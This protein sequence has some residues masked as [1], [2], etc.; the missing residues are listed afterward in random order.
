MFVNAPPK[1]PR[2]GGASGVT[3]PASDAAKKTFK[4]P[5][6][7]IRQAEALRRQDSDLIGTYSSSILPETPSVHPP[8]VAVASQPK[9]DRTFHNVF[10]VQQE[11][12]QSQGRPATSTDSL[13]LHL[14]ALK[15]AESRQ[16]PQ[17]PLPSGSEQAE[18][19]CRV[20]DQVA[21]SRSPKR[22]ISKGTSM[23]NYK[24]PKTVLSMFSNS[25]TQS[26]P[27]NKKGKKGL[28]VGVPNIT[29][30]FTRK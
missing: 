3:T 23:P 12:N 14:G 21:S 20:V 6:L 28:T 1:R 13:L 19:G 9:A 30:F 18:A 29:S 11:P 16:G 27:G 22:R 4:P 2:S 7:S 17:A 10:A 15:T 25:L 8:T 5:S 26:K 24:K